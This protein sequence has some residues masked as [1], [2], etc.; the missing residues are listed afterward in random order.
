MQ[1]ILIFFIFLTNSCC[2][3]SQ[4]FSPKKKKELFLRSGLHSVKSL[5]IMRLGHSQSA[6]GSA[7]V[8]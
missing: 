5:F 2:E 8:G 4:V 7:K 1:T 6:E 3:K